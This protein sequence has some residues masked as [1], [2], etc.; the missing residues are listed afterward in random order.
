MICSQQSNSIMLTIQYGN[1][2]EKAP[3]RCIIAHGCN[4]QGRMN[5]GFA[6]ELRQRYPANHLDYHLAFCDEGL[7]L[8]DVVYCEKYS[9]II[10]NM[11]TQEFYGRDKA[12]TYVDY[13]AVETGMRQVC[14][15]AQSMELSLHFPFI[16]AGLANGD[17]EI[18]LNILTETT[19]N[20]DATLWKL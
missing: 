3:A 13:H 19:K 20:V 1:L 5:S 9:R 4:A 12:I 10:A 11:I 18:L 6:K 2:F 15:K 7:E 17:P 16:G 8:G 14:A